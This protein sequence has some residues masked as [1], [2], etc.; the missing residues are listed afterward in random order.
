M[1]STY[2]GYGNVRYYSLYQDTTSI[3]LKNLADLVRLFRD[4]WQSFPGEDFIPREEEDILRDAHY[5]ETGRPYSPP[6][7]DNGYDSE[8]YDTFMIPVLESEEENWD[9]DL[10]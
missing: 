1:Y 7:N 6:L 2:I 5:V 4:Y 9:D 10:A 3:E 8:E